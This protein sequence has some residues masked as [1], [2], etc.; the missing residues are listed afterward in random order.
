MDA[1]LGA[2]LVLEGYTEVEGV[3]D[4]FLA[5]T[6]FEDPSLYTFPQLCVGFGTISPGFCYTQIYDIDSDDDPGTEVVTWE[7]RDLS[8]QGDRSYTLKCDVAPKHYI[9]VQ[10]Y[11]APPALKTKPGV[12]II[13]PLIGCNDND[14]PPEKWA[15]QEATDPSVVTED[16]NCRLIHLLSVV[17]TNTPCMLTM[18]SS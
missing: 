13:E 3:K 14:C 4:V 6:L 17:S 1:T 18:S 10:K 7:R 2:S 5:V 16:W 8:T 15:I 11:L 12:P 9:F